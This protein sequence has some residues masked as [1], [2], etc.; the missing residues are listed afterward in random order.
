MFHCMVNAFARSLRMTPA[1]LVLKLGHNGM[2]TFPDS[3]IQK[4]HHFQEMVDVGY[5]EGCHYVTIEMMPQSMTSD[6]SEVFP[7]L[8]GPDVIDNFNRFQQYCHVSKGVILGEKGGLG[9]AAYWDGRFCHDDSGVYDIWD[10]ESPMAPRVLW[11]E[12]WTT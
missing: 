8:F 1:E 12:V 4:T 2:G 9:H 7:I 10:G 3:N 5:E 11:R 6:G